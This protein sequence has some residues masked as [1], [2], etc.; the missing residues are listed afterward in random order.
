MNLLVNLNNTYGTI[1]ILLDL[2]AAFDTIDH[3]LLISRLARLAI[4][5]NILKLFR[6]SISDRT[7]SIQK[8][9]WHI[10]SPRNIFYGAPKGSVL[11][12]IIFN[13][14]IIPIFIIISQCPLISVQ[15]CTG[16]KQLDVK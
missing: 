6:S 2:S 15:S 12:Q 11:I 1:L 4:A 14:Y 3:I 5:G 7:Y 8:L 16:D 10:S 13:I 9:N